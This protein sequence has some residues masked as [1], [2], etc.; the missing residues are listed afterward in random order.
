[1]E[2]LGLIVTISLAL[3]GYFAAYFNNLRLAKRADRLRHITAQ[4]DELYGP[5]YVITQTSQILFQ[6]LRAQGIK[7][8][9]SDMIEDESD[10]ADKL[11]DRRIWIE[12]V[13][14]P[15]NEQ[16]DDVIINKAH[17][18]I[19][20]EMPHCLKLF[21]AHSAGYKAVIKKWQLGDSKEDASVIDYPIEIEEYAE[22]SYLKLKKQQKRLIE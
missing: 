6:A 17:L 4:I 16:L 1:M 20:E 10:S 21:L 8:G 11:S 15:L 2:L 5:L 14:Q 12:H 18:I 19:E 22:Q 13:F 7:E 9:R 3:I